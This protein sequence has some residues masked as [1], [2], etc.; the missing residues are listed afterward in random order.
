[1]AL[2]AM[3]KEVP[4]GE[5]PKTRGHAGSPSSHTHPEALTKRPPIHFTHL[6]FHGKPCLKNQFWD[7]P[8][9]SGAKTLHSQM[10]E[11]QVPILVIELGPKCCN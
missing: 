6:K 11:A 3:E 5:R 7:L 9:G 2:G 4:G 1:M 8:G 10:Q